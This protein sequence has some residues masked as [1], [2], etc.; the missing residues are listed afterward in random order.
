MT[1]PNNPDLRRALA[2]RVRFY[3]E[4]GIYDFYR[5]AGLGSA[6]STGTVESE[7]SFA[8]P[9]PLTEMP[10]KTATISATPSSAVESLTPSVAD[11]VAALKIIRDD[12]WRRTP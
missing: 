3:N 8:E 2:A 9:E 7:P 10:R 1:I 6:A 12:V 4:L 11:P 5:R